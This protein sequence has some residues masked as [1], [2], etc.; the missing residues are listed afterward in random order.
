M[1]SEGFDLVFQGLVDKRN[2]WLLF[3]SYCNNPKYILDSETGTAINDYSDN[4]HKNSI[5]SFE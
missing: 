4:L 3:G 5:W 2:I 1:K